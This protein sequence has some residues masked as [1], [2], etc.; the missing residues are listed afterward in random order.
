MMR[1]EGSEADSRSPALCSVRGPQSCGATLGRGDL[2]QLKISS[3]VLTLSQARYIRVS[4]QDHLNIN[5]L[6]RIRDLF[7]NVRLPG[8][9]HD[10]QNVII[11]K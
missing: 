2:Q 5:G 9:E 1:M 3:S 8:T 10:K 7:E 6:I 11:N 4:C